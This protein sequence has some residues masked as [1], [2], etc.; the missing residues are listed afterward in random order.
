LLKLNKKNVIDLNVF[1]IIK[2]KY[3][4]DD[5]TLIFNELVKLE[6]YKKLRLKPI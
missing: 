3:S 2:Q 5:Q 1:D 4:L 6:E